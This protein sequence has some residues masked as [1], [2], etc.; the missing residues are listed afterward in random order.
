[1]FG[2]G[3]VNYVPPPQPES[4]IDE[5]IK[6]LIAGAAD[7]GVIGVF[8][9]AIAALRQVREARELVG[10]WRERSAAD[11][12]R[13]GYTSDEID[14]CAAELAKILCVEVPE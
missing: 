12:D 8:Y 14:V 9:E 7:H 1:V 5:H 6:S 2:R 4:V 11:I 10:K 3:A 13:R